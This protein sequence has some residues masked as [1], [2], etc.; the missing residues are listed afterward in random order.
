MLS[1]EEWKRL[2][3]NYRHASPE[4]RQMVVAT[5]CDSLTEYFHRVAK[6]KTAGTNVRTT[7]VTDTYI[8]KLLQRNTVL[9]SGDAPNLDLDQYETVND[10]KRFAARCIQNIVIDKIRQLKK[11][12]ISLDQTRDD[13]EGYTVCDEPIA[14]DDATI[15]CCMTRP[16]FSLR[17]F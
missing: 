15:W 16:I 14:S 13:D 7:S 6:S 3:D 5:I 10:F 8:L 1:D 12:N 11:Y 4:T 17:A 2:Q 9:S